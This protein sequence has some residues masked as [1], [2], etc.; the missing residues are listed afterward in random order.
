MSL[1]CAATV[2][3]GFGEASCGAMS[4]RLPP[5]RSVST[6]SIVSHLEELQS[7]GVNVVMI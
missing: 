1:S 4:P 2:R 7:N 6:A 5:R 3:L